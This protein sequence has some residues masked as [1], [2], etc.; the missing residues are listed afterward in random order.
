MKKQKSLADDG[1]KKRLSEFMQQ[2]NPKPTIEQIEK[3]RKQ[4]I[5]NRGK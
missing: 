4:L 1:Y 3:L 2:I 5:E